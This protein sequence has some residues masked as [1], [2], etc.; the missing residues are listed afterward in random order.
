M[1]SCSTEQWT[2]KQPL[3]IYY[4]VQQCLLQSKRTVS[5]QSSTG[6]LQSATVITKRGKSLQSAYGQV[7]I[8]VGMGDR[9]NL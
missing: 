3:K 1:L 4:K 6:L 9:I 8:A 5:L 2:S 7:G